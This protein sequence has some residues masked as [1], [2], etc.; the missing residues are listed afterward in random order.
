MQ[1]A[2]LRFVIFTP[3]SAFRFSLFAA[4]LRFSLLCF[5]FRPAAAG[6]GVVAQ[7]A[8]FRVRISVGQKELLR[9]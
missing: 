5:R 3:L 2:G 9:M 8:R 1:W 7:V 6:L 4:P